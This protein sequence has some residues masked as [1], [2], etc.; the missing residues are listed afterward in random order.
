MTQNNKIQTIAAVIL[1]TLGLACG[2]S[3]P[4]P[5]TPASEPAPA[6]QGGEETMPSSATETQGDQQIEQ[7]HTMPESTGTTMEGSTR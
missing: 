5:A 1:V 3:E 6:T 2:D 4:P 7:Q